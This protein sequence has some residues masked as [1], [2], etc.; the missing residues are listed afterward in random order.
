MA[1]FFSRSPF[2]LERVD[3]VAS[4]CSR[5][6]LRQG[7]FGSQLRQSRVQTM[8]SQERGCS[9]VDLAARGGFVGLQKPPLL[10]MCAADPSGHGKGISAA[11]AKPTKNKEN[12][13]AI[14]SI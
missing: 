14:G 11:F 2:V 3:G 1:I 9:L 6:P 8:S 7:Q 4:V 12:A 10:S 5:D 13:N